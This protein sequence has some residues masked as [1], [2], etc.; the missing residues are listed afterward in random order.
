MKT[1]MTTTTSQEENILFFRISISTGEKEGQN[2]ED[3]RHY[4]YVSGQKCKYCYEPRM[5]ADQGL[6][7]CWPVAETHGF[8]HVPPLEPPGPTLFTPFS[9]EKW[10]EHRTTFTYGSYVAR[11]AS[12][13]ILKGDPREPA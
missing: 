9:Y 3:G 2:Y 7:W 10:S 11:D 4:D 5:V 12:R 6:A 1:N 13:K 8:D